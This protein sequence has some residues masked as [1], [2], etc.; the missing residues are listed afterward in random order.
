PHSGVGLEFERLLLVVT[1]MENVR[2]ERPFARTAR[3]A[4]F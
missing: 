1:G 2:D 4:D 3:N